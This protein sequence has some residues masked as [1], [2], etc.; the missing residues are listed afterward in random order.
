MTMFRDDE[1]DGDGVGALLCCDADS[2][3]NYIIVA[4]GDVGAAD[5]I[6]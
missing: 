3:G 2:V 6:W 1:A 4:D 5:L